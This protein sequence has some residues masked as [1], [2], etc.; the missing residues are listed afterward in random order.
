MNSFDAYLPALIIISAVYIALLLIV[1]TGGNADK[2]PS[3]KVASL[4]LLSSWPLTLVL[5]VIRSADTYFSG[6]NN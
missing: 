2:T 1:A 5:L 6:K 4:F 3:G